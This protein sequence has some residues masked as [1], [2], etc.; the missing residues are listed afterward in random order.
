M[1][2]LE[3]IR[4]IE[5][6]VAIAGPLVGRYLAQL[7][8]EV[9]KVESRSTGMGNIS[10]GPAWA[11]KELGQAAAD[12]NA[13]NN[14]FNSEKTS[15]ALDLKH[16]EGKRILSALIAK[17]DV[18]LTN[19]SMP[20]IES[21]AIDADSVRALN[22]DIVYVGMPGFG[23]VPGPYREYKSW[24]PN[25]SALSGLDSLTGDPDRQPVLTPTPLID[26]VSGYQAVV[27]VISALLHRGATGKG[28]VIDVSQF[29][30]AAAVLG[31]YVAQ[32]AL[33]GQVP[34][35]D[36]NHKPD[37]APCD[38]FPC[39]GDDRWVAITVDTDDE[40][41]ALAE[42]A[43][44]AE[45]STDA[46][47]VTV[48]ARLAHQDELYE[49]ISAWTR[50]CTPREVALRLQAAGVQ[51]A[52]LADG[53]DMVADPQ[54][55]ARQ[56]WR[57]VAHDRMGVDL[58]SGFPI[59][60]MGTPPRV[61]RAAASYGSGTREV[62]TDVLGLSEQEVDSAIE[63]G[64]ASQQ[65][66]IPDAV[67]AS[68]AALERPYR[69][70][71]F[72]ILRVDPGMGA[73]APDSGPAVRAPEANGHD[74][75]SA[76]RAPL[77]GYRVIDLSLPLGAYG[78]RMLADLGAEVIR[79]EPPAG[80]D[81][82]R[83]PPS[84]DGRSLFHAYLD[85]GKQSVRLDLDDEAGREAFA[86][87]LATADLL[88]D[89]TPASYL[90]GRGF[91]W[92]RL[93]AINPALIH[94]SVT[95]FGRTGP[96]RD[97]KA[98]DLTLWALSGMLQ[99]T[100]YPDRRPLMPGAR[101]SYYLVGANGAIGAAAALLARETT[102]RGQRVDISAH[103]VMVGTSGNML[104]Q[105]EDFAPRR[106]AGSR[107]LGAAPWGYFRAQDRLVCL[108]ALFPAHWEILSAWIH[109]ETGN[110]EALDER[111]KGAAAQRYA[112]V[113]AV[114]ALINSLTERYPAD[115]FCVEAQRRG[116]PATPV[117]G[118]A[119]ILRDPQL[120]AVGYWQQMDVPGLG[121]VPWPGAPYRLSLTPA[122]MRGPAP[123]LRESTPGEHARE[124]V[125]TAPAEG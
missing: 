123:E 69:P 26:Y 9:I 1:H 12:L 67:H 43:A 40:W 56:F 17:S 42:V 125:A 122:R 29:E 34:L 63:S 86:D 106:R 31:P 95:P 62:L 25:L 5:C 84:A 14:T 51:A 116:I 65:A 7:G 2:P 107:A 60:L 89:G 54:L 74:R 124:R 110:Q 32:V 16:P 104:A 39:R 20:A 64:A 80:S 91:N 38:V 28:Q 114:E 36:G 27:A 99:L 79:V 46:R 30:A 85:A 52:Q 50:T 41:R 77:E 10:A 33:T 48:Q 81:L 83:L 105:I 59:R 78:S 102:G 90:P 112:H 118:V 103:E 18:F 98:D 3:G 19:L 108:L 75:T 44:H 58:I 68:G 6:G 73:D 87:L 49:A 57:M 93:Q 72:P 45:W 92:E 11:P 94:V 24:G 76:R 96:Y 21:L 115:A 111:F 121:E 61:E 47:F 4:V 23:A 55:E 22:P 119:D 88:Y 37:G 97:W 71:A 113:D 120:Q 35:R 15:L 53:W 101:L 117:N 66:E 70:W 82:R 109:E 13:G 100:G 8:A